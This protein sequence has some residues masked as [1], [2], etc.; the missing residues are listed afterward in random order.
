MSWREWFEKGSFVNKVIMQGGEILGV[1]D[2]EERRYQAYKARLIEELR[3]HRD[4]TELLDCC[5][6]ETTKKLQAKF[7][8]LNG[9]PGE[10]RPWY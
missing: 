6:P 7:P 4:F 3:V 10:P 1:S 9:K 5:D 2:A 8:E